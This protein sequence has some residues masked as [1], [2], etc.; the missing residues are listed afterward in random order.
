MSSRKPC[1]LTPGSLGGTARTKAEKRRGRSPS[2]SLRLRPSEV[3]QPQPG[4][5]FQG[6]TERKRDGEL[7]AKPLRAPVCSSPQQRGGARPTGQAQPPSKTKNSSVSCIFQTWP[8]K[9]SSRE[10]ELTRGLI[11]QLSCGE[12]ESHR[13][14]PVI[15]QCPSYH[16]WRETP[17]PTPPEYVT[18]SLVLHREIEQR[19]F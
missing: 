3:Y 8:P 9:D 7:A 18:L 6:K 1:S 2:P 14:D 16:R 12:K 15:A 13:K 4:R 10:S 5:P 19:P 17:A 11:C